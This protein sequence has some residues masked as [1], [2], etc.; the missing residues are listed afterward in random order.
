MRDK[1]VPD[2]PTIT[3]KDLGCDT[4][5]DRC[6]PLAHTSAK[7]PAPLAFCR[8]LYGNLPAE[9]DL[10]LCLNPIPSAPGKESSLV[11]AIPRPKRFRTGPA[12][13]LEISTRV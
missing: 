1:D 12:V 8:F 5:L 10:W 4:C 3:R 13:S 7:S 2:H 6:L 9:R 11:I